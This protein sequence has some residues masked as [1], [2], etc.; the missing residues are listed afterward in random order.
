MVRSTESIRV[1]LIYHLESMCEIECTLQCPYYAH[2][3]LY[4]VAGMLSKV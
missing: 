4:S 2:D 1:I 3:T